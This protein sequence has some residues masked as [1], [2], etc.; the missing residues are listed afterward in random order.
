[1]YVYIH[2][3]TKHVTL[4]KD[5]PNFYYKHIYVRTYV[6]YIHIKDFDV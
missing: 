2:T 3:Y 6:P 1:M 5:I 4:D